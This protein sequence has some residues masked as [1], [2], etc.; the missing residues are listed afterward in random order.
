MQRA[1]TGSRARARCTPDKTCRQHTSRVVLVLAALTLVQ[2][3]LL[4]WLT[5]QRILA[6]P[7]LAFVPTGDHATTCTVH[8]ASLLRRGLPGERSTSHFST[9]PRFKQACSSKEDS[10][11]N[12][13]LCMPGWRGMS[14]DKRT[15]VTPCSLHHCLDWSRC[16]LGTPLTVHVYDKPPGCTASWLDSKTTAEYRNLIDT[17]RASARHVADPSHACLLVPWVDTLCNG[18]RC[19]DT[20][21][22]APKLDVL[23][24]AL[25]QLVHWRGTGANHLIFDMSSSHAPVLPVGRGIYLATAFWGAGD[26]YRHGHDQ[27]LPLWNQ[28]WNSETNVR[29]AEQARQRRVHDTEPLLLTFKGQRMHFCTDEHCAPADLAA[30]ITSGSLRKREAYEREWVRSQLRQLNNGHDI[31]M[32]THCVRELENIQS[33]DKQCQAGCVEDKQQYDTADFVELLINSTFALVAP[34][35]TP[36]SYRLAEALSYGAIPVIVSDFLMLPYRRLF[37]WPSFSIRVSESE[38]LNLPKLLRSLPRNVVRSMQA[39]AIE[40]YERCFRTPGAIALC[41]IADLEVQLGLLTTA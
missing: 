7:G 24:H 31:I 5:T 40:A 3:L 21:T 9:L 36:N 37:D 12:C 35:I 18:N 32:I 38:L 41:A 27:P 16:P 4:S 1:R 17:L 2:Q 11:L 26:S 8:N 19:T 28:R 23:A 15:Y 29:L 22:E 30:A 33:C 14:C 13:T 10:R 25:E 20:W 6:L 39:S 34:G